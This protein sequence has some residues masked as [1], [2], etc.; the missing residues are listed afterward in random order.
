MHNNKQW[1]IVVV[2]AVVAI[3]GWLIAGC[4]GGGGTTPASTGSV[5]GSTVDIVSQFGIGGLTVTVGGQQDVT[6]GN[7]NFVVTG[8]LPGVRDV[9]VTPTTLWEQV[10]DAPD[11]VVVAGQTTPVGVILVRDPNSGPPPPPGLP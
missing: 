6:D 1:T 7:G 8:V 10:G 11:V 9:V 3:V 2:I 4:G 5:S